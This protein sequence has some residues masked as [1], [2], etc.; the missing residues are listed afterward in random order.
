MQPHPM[1]L[2]SE[3]QIRQQVLVR[4]PMNIIK[5]LCN[6]KMVQLVRKPNS[7]RAQSNLIPN[8]KKRRHIN[9]QA[10]NQLSRLH[11]PI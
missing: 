7:I 11:V 10:F 9:Q 3:G 8:P 1:A 5:T 2:V 6:R 4:Q